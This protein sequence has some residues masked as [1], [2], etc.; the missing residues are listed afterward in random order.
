MFNYFLNT[1][2]QIVYLNVLKILTH[3]VVCENSVFKEVIYDFSRTMEAP[4]HSWAE[5]ARGLHCGAQKDIG[6]VGIFM[7]KA[8][9]LMF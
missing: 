9:D 3:V 6:S 8:L 7:Y 2:S 5:W 4:V 1:L